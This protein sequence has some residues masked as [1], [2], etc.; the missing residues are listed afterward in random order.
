MPQYVCSGVSEEH[1]ASILMAEVWAN[2]SGTFP[3]TRQ[4]GAA[5]LFIYYL[6]NNVFISSDY[7]SVTSNIRMGNE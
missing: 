5:Y 3:P 7:K 4:H 1:G 6:I 2:S